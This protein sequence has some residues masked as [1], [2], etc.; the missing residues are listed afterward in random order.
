MTNAGTVVAHGLVRS[1]ACRWCGDAFVFVVGSR[2]RPQ[3][4]CSVRCRKRAELRVRVL[5]REHAALEMNIRVEGG[6]ENRLRLRE[7][8]AEIVRLGSTVRFVFTAFTPR[9]Y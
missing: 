3:R 6:L 2:G 9:A 1:V 4:Y 7:I 8:E 5:R